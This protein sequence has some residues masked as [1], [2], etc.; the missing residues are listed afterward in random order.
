MFY[1][2][3]AW[4][5]SGDSGKSSL[6]MK[7]AKSSSIWKDN[8]SCEFNRHFWFL[9]PMPKLAHN[10]KVY[11]SLELWYPS[12][13]WWKIWKVWFKTNDYILFTQK[14]H[15]LCLLHY[16]INN[17]TISEKKTRSHLSIVFCLLLIFNKL[18]FFTE[19]NITL[20]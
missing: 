17:K 11:F 19:T 15:S 7:S 20:T 8:P 18:F 12:F 2:G 5:G 3:E 13:P 6:N 14:T 4:K 9:P 1:L 16:S 10:Q